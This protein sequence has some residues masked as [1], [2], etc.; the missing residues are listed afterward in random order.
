[1]LIK[2]AWQKQLACDICLHVPEP[3]GACWLVKNRQGPS[4]SE[5]LESTLSSC[6]QAY[7]VLVHA[8]IIRQLEYLDI[9]GPKP[10]F[11]FTK[12]QHV[13]GA[14]VLFEVRKAP[15]PP[16]VTIKR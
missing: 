8:R 6:S 7:L 1:M 4:G 5:E 3:P 13:E 16:L 14:E 10:K 2:K 12:T 15:L 11:S 9:S